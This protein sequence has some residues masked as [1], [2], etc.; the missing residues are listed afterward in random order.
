MTIS[1]KIISLGMCS[2][3]KTTSIVLE[4]IINYNMQFTK[5]IIVVSEILFQKY[6]PFFSTSMEKGYITFFHFEAW[7]S[8]L[9]ALPSEWVG[10]FCPFK[11]SLGI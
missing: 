1:Q 2:N 3:Y 6:S 4:P 9:L 10:Y 5:I 11:L 7:P 8:N